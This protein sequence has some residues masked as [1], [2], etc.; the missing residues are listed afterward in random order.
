MSSVNE[1]TTPQDTQLESAL[2]SPFQL[3]KTKGPVKLVPLHAAIQKSSSSSRH[4]PV[5]PPTGS[6][7]SST[8]SID[9][10]SSGDV[11]SPKSALGESPFSFSLHKTSLSGL[12]TSTFSSGSSILTNNFNPDDPK[13]NELLKE[14]QRLKRDIEAK[15]RD[16]ES[17]EAK[18]SS[19]VKSI[20][21]FWSPELKK[22]RAIRKEEE[23]KVKVVEEKCQTCQHQL[24]ASI[25]SA[26]SSFKLYCANYYCFLMVC[27][28]LLIGKYV[29]LLLIQK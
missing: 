18:L 17:K 27:L 23:E 22:E 15:N 29:I 5:T 28:A 14:I 9:T 25:L 8:S 2:R 24:K 20:K 11:V 3:N 16:I 19:S 4:A 21:Q 10:V 1:P 13:Q 6:A 7:S 26:N 12:S